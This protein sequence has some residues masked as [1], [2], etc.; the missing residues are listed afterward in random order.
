M[1]SHAVDYFAV[2]GKSV[3]SLACEDAT[4]NKSAQ[5]WND[6]I[7]DIEVFY[8]GIDTFAYKPHKVFFVIFV[9]L[10]TDQHSPDD[11]WEISTSSLEGGELEGPF[12]GVR[13]RS[14]SKRFD[15]ITQVNIFSYHRLGVLQIT[16]IERSTDITVSRW[17]ANT[18]WV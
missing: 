5:A 6:A 1:S 3:G 8:S 4:N 17:N 18:C 16:I 9:V 11:S 14:R 12:I 15:H 10:I 13:R 2:L 7:T